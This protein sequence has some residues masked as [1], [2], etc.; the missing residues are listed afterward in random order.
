[1]KQTLF[2]ALL[3]ALPA[4]TAGQIGAMPEQQGWGPRMRVTPFVG[5]GPAFHSKGDLNIASGAELLTDTYDFEYASGPV[6]GLN[7][8]LRLHSR[9]SLIASG[10]WSRRDETIFATVDSLAADIGSDFWMGRAAL[11]VRLQDRETDLQFRELSA[12]LYAGAAFVQ[13]RPEK[14]P[15]APVE[16]RENATHWGVHVGAEAE[17]PLTDRHLSLTAGFEDTMMFWN[18]T[19]LEHHVRRYYQDE[20]GAGAIAEADPDLS[21]MFTLR[22]GLAFRFG[23]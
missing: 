22:L 7:L 17:V 9:Y 21:H 13:E 2:V 4:G 14:H 23:R 16:W 20:H 18:A 15:A 12:L 8:E 11:A 1:M 3:L 5:F 6:A 10:A 19:A